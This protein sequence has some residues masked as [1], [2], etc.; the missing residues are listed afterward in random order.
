MAV[1]TIKATIRM[2]YG[3]EKDLEPDKLVTG[4][5]AVATDTKKIWMCFRPGLVLRMATYEAFEQDMQEIQTILATCQDI[6]V[7]VERFM[8]LAEQHASQAEVW[9]VASKSWAVGGTGT[10][11][12]EDADN[13]KYWSQQS[14]N[15]ADRA[16]SEADRAASIAGFSVDAE[17]SETSTNPVQN[18]VITGELNKKLA[19]NGDASDT[20]VLFEQSEERANVASGE[21]FSVFAGKIKK[22]FAD[23]KIV[24]FLNPT[25]N[26]LANIAGTALDAVQGKVLDGKIATLN[27]NLSNLFD[28]SMVDVTTETLGEMKVQ[29]VSANFSVPSGYK[30]FFSFA[31][32]TNGWAVINLREYKLN[33]GVQPVHILNAGPGERAFTVSVYTI[34][35]KKGYGI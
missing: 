15:E 21:K 12:G 29:T 1:Q 7:A 20:S 23:L 13:S 26:L 28:I 2:R 35:I 8:Q 31:V 18:R 33:D 34:W 19:K 27:N 17:L 32:C 25:N 24:A 6:Q 10:R 9:S 14:K 11:A 4:E 16:K 22:W 5:W 3:L 30:R